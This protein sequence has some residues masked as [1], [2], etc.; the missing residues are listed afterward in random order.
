MKRVLLALAISS[1]SSSGL[2][3]AST[4]QLL[5]NGMNLPKLLTE[6]RDELGL[7]SQQV[8]MI[9][10]IV[11]EAHAKGDSL[12]TELRE[13]QGDFEHLLQNPETKA[14]AATAA[15]TKVLE[16]ES[17]VKHFILITLI[18][19]RDQLTPEQQAKARKLSGPASAKSGAAE[20]RLQEKAEKVRLAF[21]SLGIDPPSELVARGA[22][23]EQFLK[24]GNLAKAETALDELIS[25]TGL[26]E[27][28]SK[29]QPDFSKFEPGSTDLDTLKARFESV[30]E[31]AKT[32]TSLPVL[33]RLVK[34]KE[35][36]EAAKTAEDAIRV[37]RVL[38]YAEGVL[39]GKS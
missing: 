27:T 25:D 33:R 34:A 11:E 36:F 9:K 23:I 4:D 30:Q 20:T 21:K 8:A 13:K 5:T 1:L 39:A 24:D 29:D 16:A 28:D 10:S 12:G 18:S 35:E 3:A 32:V 38:T 19:V 17:A 6:H 15:L 2:R 7:S 14:E 26:N 37:G 22:A 31:K